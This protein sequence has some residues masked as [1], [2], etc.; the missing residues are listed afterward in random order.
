MDRKEYADFLLK[1][2][3]D[4]EYYEKKYPKRDL[5]DGAMVTRLAPS[6]T[7][8]VHLGS[9]DVGFVDRIMASRTTLHASHGPA[10]SDW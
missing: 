5:K 7:G 9:L 3:H 4:Y 1:T 8:F 2:E 10:I 6:P